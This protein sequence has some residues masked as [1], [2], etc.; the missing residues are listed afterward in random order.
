MPAMVFVCDCACFL[1][2]LSLFIF[3]S[4]CKFGRPEVRS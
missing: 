3:I 4:L 1:L 2:S